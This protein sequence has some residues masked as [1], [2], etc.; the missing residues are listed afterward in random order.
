[1]LLQ[2]RHEDGSPMSDEEL[3]DEL[4]TLLVAGHETTAARSPGPSSARCAT[5]SVLERL[6]EEARR[7]RRLRR[8]RLQ[9][10]AAAAPDPGA[11]AAPA[12]RADGD[13]R[14]AAARRAS[15]W[16]P[17]STSCTAAPDVY[18]DPLRLPARAL[19]RAARRHLHLDPV[20]RRRAPL[21]GRE[22][23]AVRDADR[24]ARAGQPARAARRRPAAGAHRPPRDHARARARR[25]GRGGAGA[26]ARAGSPRRRDD[27]ARSARPARAR[28]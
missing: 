12:D 15:T 16:R 23:R 3:R 11:R 10:D 14:P 8:R 5:P 21:P 27:R 24:A 9:G 22:L 17:A 7:R 1:M 26:P 18:P 28:G 20:R 19:P 6:R 25:R 4:M 13:R 2:A